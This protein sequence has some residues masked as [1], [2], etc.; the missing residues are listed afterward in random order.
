MRGMGRREHTMI[1]YQ[2]DNDR[3]QVKVMFTLSGDGLDGETIAVVGDFNDW[4]PVATVLRKSGANVSATVRLRP[5]E[6][7]AFH[8]LAGDGRRFDDGA[9]S[10]EGHGSIDRSNYV[11]DL[12]GFA[13][14]KGRTQMQSQT[15]DGRAADGSTKVARHGT[16]RRLEGSNASLDEEVAQSGGCGFIHLA[17]GRVCQL[18]YGHSEGC[19]FRPR[20]AR[21]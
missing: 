13:S 21:D 9:A 11:I 1:R 15:T 6:R 18:A 3:E 14:P 17:S 4:N 20:L 16:E 2:Y 8:Y 12:T 5:G 19:R 7:Y 10:H